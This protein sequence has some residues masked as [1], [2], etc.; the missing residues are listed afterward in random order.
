[1]IR[2]NYFFINYF[3]NNYKKKDILLKVKKNIK[4]L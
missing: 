1:M 3:I 4:I 2:D